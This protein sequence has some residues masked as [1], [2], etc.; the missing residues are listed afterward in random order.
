MNDIEHVCNLL[1]YGNVFKIAILLVLVLI[2]WRVWWTCGAAKATGSVAYHEELRAAYGELTGSALQMQR[3]RPS[4]VSR[5]LIPNRYLT[6]GAAT[7]T[8]EWIIVRNDL[9]PNLWWDGVYTSY[10]WAVGA[11]KGFT[12]HAD[13]DCCVKTKDT[14]Y[15]IMEVDCSKAE[16]PDGMFF[17]EPNHPLNLRSEKFLAGITI[18]SYGGKGVIQIY[19]TARDW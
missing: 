12:K 18:A 1:G 11:L 19:R 2:L 3:A 9:P 8:K 5:H 6:R 14:R 16:I 4:S 10:D 13:L 15:F 17:A 7:M